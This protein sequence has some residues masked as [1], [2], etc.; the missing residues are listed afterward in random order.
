MKVFIGTDHAG[1]E[2]KEH[3]KRYLAGQGFD[4]DDQGAHRYDENDDYPDF[5]VPVARQVAAHPGSRGIVLGG[6]GQ[7]E[8]IAAN[9]VR[10]VRAALYYGGNLEIVRLS[11]LHNDT[12][13]L[14]LGAR[15]VGT[16]EA[17]EAVRLWLATDFSD[18]ERHARRIRKIDLTAG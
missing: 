1:L 9:K 5:I 18:E 16:D 4:V 15:F 6:S 12:N 10:G 13:V 17:I 14:S 2:L 3:I 8:A 7:G 11:R